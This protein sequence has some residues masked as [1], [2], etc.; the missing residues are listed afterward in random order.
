MNDRLL[1]SIAPKPTTWS[2]PKDGKISGKITWSP[3]IEVRF[4]FS[5]AEPPDEKRVQR[6]VRAVE[7][8]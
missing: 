7:I 1:P 3:G 2:Q 6:R 5:Q 4:S 8:T